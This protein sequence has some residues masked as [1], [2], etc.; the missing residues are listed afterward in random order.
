MD[1][2]ETESLLA[3]VAEVEE[4][5]DGDEE[6]VED[7]DGTYLNRF[8]MNLIS[9]STKLNISLTEVASDL[10]YEVRA[11]NVK[12]KKKRKRKKKRHCVH[13]HHTTIF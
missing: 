6:E 9:L 8:S 10:I 13:H 11:F 4:D 3:L 1:D 2:D 7:E 12:I 5:E